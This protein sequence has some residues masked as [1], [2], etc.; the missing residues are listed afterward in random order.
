MDHF[1]GGKSTFKISEFFYKL[2]S[3]NNR[4]KGENTPNRVTL[5]DRQQTSLGDCTYRDNNDLQ[6]LFH[7]S[8]FD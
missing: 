7:A 2:P 1:F 4:P 5:L 3:I 6:I 8:I